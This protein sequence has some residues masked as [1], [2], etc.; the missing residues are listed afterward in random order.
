MGFQHCP[1]G[2]GPGLHRHRTTE[3]FLVL[4]GRFRCY[5][6][7]AG[8]SG[9]TELGTWDIAVVPGPVWRGLENVGDEDALMIVVLGGPEPGI[10][11][12]PSVVERAAA[13]G[14]RM[15]ADGNLVRERTT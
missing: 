4:S 8:G 15:D 2:Q 1:P 11:W 7:D 5:W 12:H 13:Q 6:E 3:A 9:E 14:V 10:E